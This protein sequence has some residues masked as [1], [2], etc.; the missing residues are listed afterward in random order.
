MFAAVGR[1]MAIIPPDER[2]KGL[3][4]ERQTFSMAEQWP[5][6]NSDAPET[7]TKTNPHEELF[8]LIQTR[9]RTFRVSNPSTRRCFYR[10]AFQ[11]S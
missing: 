4:G 1:K 2:K 7:W 10:D 9:I 8:L 11:A 6:R 3:R 5:E